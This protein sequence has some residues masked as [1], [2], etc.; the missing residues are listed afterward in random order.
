MIDRHQIDRRWAA[1][2]AVPLVVL[3]A[4]IATGTRG[5]DRLWLPFGQVVD[6]S[7]VMALTALALT[8]ALAWCAISRWWG[9][10]A[11]GLLLMAIAGFWPI[12]Q[13]N[14]FSGPVVVGIGTHG[15]HRNDALALVP[16]GLGLAAIVV[17]ERRRRVGARAIASTQGADPAA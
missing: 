10:M 12:V 11:L 14:K 8:V 1:L 2:A 7:T 3:V 13:E 6:T 9:L 5:P 17:A 15:L 4:W 16:G